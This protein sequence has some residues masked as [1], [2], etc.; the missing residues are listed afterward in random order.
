MAIRYLTLALCV[1][2]VILFII[3]YNDFRFTSVLFKRTEDTI[4]KNVEYLFNARHKFTDEFCPKNGNTFRFVT[5]NILSD[6]F[7]S[8]E[9]AR[10]MYKYCPRYALDKTYRRP[11]ILKELFGYHSDFMALQE[12]DEDMFKEYLLSK[13]SEKGYNGLFMKKYRGNPEGEALFY[14]TERYTH[15][16]DLSINVKDALFHTSNKL[17]YAKLSNDAINIISNRKALGLIHI[18]KDNFANNSKNICIL[19]THLYYLSNMTHIRLAQM[20]ILL[21]YVS[22]LVSEQNTNIIVTGDLNSPPSEPLIR[23]LSGYVINNQSDPLV[24]K[25]SGKIDLHSPIEFQ[26]PIKFHSLSGIPKYTCYAPPEVETYDYVFG[27]ST[28]SAFSSVPIP[29]EEDIK[30]FTGNPSIAYPSDH[31]AIVLD[32]LNKGLS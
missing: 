8:T 3:F 26:P 22:S 24:I 20:A 7:A 9:I 16:K 18:F 28:F 12:C 13:L 17:L 2:I 31:F 4:D 6:G 11:L 32:I 21:N 15:M 27:S 23:F 14:R 19:N 1:G 25:A 30:P 5:Y 10:K 29:S